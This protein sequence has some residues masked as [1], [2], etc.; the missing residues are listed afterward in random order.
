V[1]RRALSAAFGLAFVLSLTQSSEAFVWPNAAERIEKQLSAKD[2]SARRRAAGRLSE[3][4][5][6]LAKR[7]VLKAMKDPDTEVRLAAAD[8]VMEHH[9]KG[10]GEIVVAWLNDPERRTRLAAA[11]TLRIDPVSKAVAPLGRVLG[12][13][14]SSVRSAAA[15]ALGASKSK[16][17]V[18][19]LLGHIDDSVPAVRIAIVRALARLAD[20][21]AVVPLI[22]KIQDS[23]AQVRRIVARTLGELGDPRASSALILA[24]RDSDETVRMAALEALGL[25]KDKSAT[26]AIT[27]AIGDDPRSL[28]RAA[29]LSALARIGTT[30]AVDTLVEQLGKDDPYD[31]EP[32]ARTAVARMGAAAVP[33]LKQCL[34][35]QPTRAVADGC[36]RALADVHAEKSGALIV[37]ALTRGVITPGA[38][39]SALTELRDPKTLPSVLEHLAASDPVERRAA[40]DAATTLLDPRKPDGRAVDPIAQALEAARSSKAERAAL[41]RLL[42]RTGSTRAVKSLTPL[43]AAEDAVELRIAAIEALGL[44]PPG[45]QDKVLLKALEAEE[46]QVRMAAALALR[47][48]ASGPATRTLLDRFERAAE[49]DRGALSM[50][51]GGGLSRAKDPNL[52]DRTERLMLASRDGQRD[53]LIEAMGR[54]PDKRAVE[55]LDAHAKSAGLV[56]DRAK[57]AEALAGR[58]DAIGA[59]TRLA[60]DVDGAVRANAVWALGGVGRSSERALLVKALDD[61]DVA[62]AGNAAAALGRLARRTKSPVTKELCARLTDARSY[63]R[64]NSLAGLRVSGARCANGE[65]RTILSEDRSDV[66][67]RAAALLIVNV[68]S[69]DT[70]ADDTALESC[71]A[72]DRDGSVAAACA[73]RKDQLPTSVEPVSV[74]VVPIGESSPVAKAPFALVR[75]DGLM[76]LGIADRRGQLFEA[77]APTGVISLAVPAPLAR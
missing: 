67:R 38:A 2:V 56:A 42:G 60:A 40:V 65:E 29:A 6:G 27:A 7:L 68:P 11:E 1:P 49:Q 22:G 4:P 57:V 59:L 3:L 5:I 30:E 44:L 20:K 10:T 46:P 12:D 17:A 21:R 14:D 18:L 54:Y 58:K 24:L 36:A 62:V 72:E 33:R 39:L 28:V 48:A 74:F 9:L 71:S 32:P 52:F 73:T 16:D 47:R 70:H 31:A 64:A 23:R 35:G 53:A 45:G 61:R 66:V 13:P 26:L 77:D 34:A 55:R 69:K 37:D 43:A 50:A 25:L 41:A 15:S 8:L 19:P 63:V 75:S 51:L 76:R